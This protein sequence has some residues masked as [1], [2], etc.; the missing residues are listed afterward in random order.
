[1]RH[2]VLV[3]ALVAVV[4]PEVAAWAAFPGEN[5]KIAFVWNR[6]RDSL[7][8]MMNPDGTGKVKLSTLQ[9]LDSYSSWAADDKRIVI[10]NTNPDVPHFD[11]CVMK[12]DGREVERLTKTQAFESFPA[13]QSLPTS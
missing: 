11:I 6:A 12:A 10:A 1:M 13:W 8:F 3:L 7:V 5:G 9:W 4:L 2:I